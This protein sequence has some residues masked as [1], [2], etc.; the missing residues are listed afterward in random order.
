MVRVF[1]VPSRFLALSHF[2]SLARCPLCVSALVGRYVP[3]S[4]FANDTQMPMNPINRERVSTMDTMA[5]RTTRLPWVRIAEIEPHKLQWVVSEVPCALWS[6]F[7]ACL[8]LTFSIT[9]SVRRTE[10][11]VVLLSRCFSIEYINFVPSFRTSATSEICP[12]RMGRT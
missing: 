8:F 12:I 10:E 3:K 5:R 6:E 1:A 9:Q 2:C 7:S 11:C 4:C